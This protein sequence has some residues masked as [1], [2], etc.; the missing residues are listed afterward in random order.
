MRF[1][2]NLSNVQGCDVSWCAYNHEQN[3]HARAIT[4]GEGIHPACDTFFPAERQARDIAHTAGVGACKVSACRHNSD[5][6]CAAGA[7][8]V[9]VH[10]NHAD[11][12]TFA[13][14]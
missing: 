7:I 9:S 11:C 14:R 4:I 6:E 1:D 2:L 3:C 13:P 12:M 8:H 10:D 5:L